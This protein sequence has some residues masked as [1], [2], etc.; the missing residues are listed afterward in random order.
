MP[1]I[2]LEPARISWLHTVNNQPRRAAR[3]IG[4]VLFDR[5]SLLGAGTVAEIFHTANEI[6]PTKAA[7]GPVYEVRFLSAEGGSVACTLSARVW[8][9]GLDARH[10]FRFDALF[11]AGGIGAKA[12]AQDERLLSLLRIA[13]HTAGTIKPIGEGRALLAAAGIVGRKDWH[14]DVGVPPTMSASG[15]AVNE[16]GDRYESMR[17]ALALIKRDLGLEVARDVA[18]QVMPGMSAKLLNRLGDVG[19]IGIPEKIRI[20]A[21]WMEEN[22][23]RSLSVADAAHVA[24]MSER[25]FLR[26]FK[27]EMRVT[28]SDYLLQVRLKIACAFLTDTE[29]PVDKIARRSGTGNGDRLAKIFR[30]RMAVSPTE[31]RARSRLTSSATE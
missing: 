14:R 24:A 26:R 28:P 8:T 16:S 5:F 25:N 2:G 29:L 9:D 18:E 23:D 6:S 3:Q 1:Y 10:Q 12:A 19:T 27:D 21:R 15:E 17:S 13:H 31:Y 30:K 11:V 20:A 22:C 4:I 7:D